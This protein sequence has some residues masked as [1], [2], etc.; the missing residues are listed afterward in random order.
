MFKKFGLVVSLFI[1]SGCTSIVSLDKRVSFDAE[2]FA[3]KIDASETSNKILGSEKNQSLKIVVTP[4]SF[5]GS[6]IALNLDVGTTFNAMIKQL[7]TYSGFN[8]ESNCYEIIVSLQ[9]PKV[10]Y[11]L[12]MMTASGYDYGGFECDVQ[13]KIAPNSKPITKH[14][15][16]TKHNKND[17]FDGSNRILG[18]VLDSME[19]VVLQL[20]KDI[21][22]NLKSI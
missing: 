17:E 16:Y 13:Y 7:S 11:S 12:N 9:N 4:D 20:I 10:K 6:A 22:T 19:F 8:C 15:Q 1:L 5:T 21:K 14:Y 18:P 3:R 2:Q